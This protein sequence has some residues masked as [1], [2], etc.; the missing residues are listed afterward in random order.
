[1]IIR[2]GKYSIRDWRKTDAPSIARY[3]DNREIWRN[4]RDGF[5]SPYRLSDAE[6]YL[7]K[8]A[9]QNP[10]TF[11]AIAEKK[12]AIGSIGV[13][14]GEDVHRFSAEMGY[15]LA[16]PFWKKG[17]MSRVVREFTDYVFQNFE[18]NRIFA[19]PY[20]GNTAS[21]RVL[22]KAGFTLEGTMRA[23]VVKDGKVRDQWLYAKIRQ[24]I[25]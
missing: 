11:F 14:M 3:A 12:E 21:A 17:I 13:V 1:M 19:E 6:R 8:V 9:Q 25:R 15:W 18:L 10:R 16:E 7:E 24:G 23:N 4:L 5:P 20:T 2:F 22:E